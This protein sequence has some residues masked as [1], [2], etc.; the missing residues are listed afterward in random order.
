MTKTLLLIRH[1][2]ADS[3]NFDIKD[4][5]RPLT[6]DGEIMASKVG[7]Y[8]KKADLEP[9]AI[10]AS[11]ALRTRQTAGFFVEQL[12]FDANKI[13]LNENLYEASTRILLGVINNIDPDLDNV[14]IVAHNPGISYLA[15]Y[16]TGEII[17]NVSPAGI[18]QLKFDGDWAEIS[19]KNMDLVSYTN[20]SQLN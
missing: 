2:E 5:E 4:I 9:D 8:L 12:S 7:R 19:E 14:V 3:T 16:M 17:G 13:E 6:S 18:I 15:E 11:T 20:S 1:A 10:M